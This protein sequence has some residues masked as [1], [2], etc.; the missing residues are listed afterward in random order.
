MLSFTKIQLRM[1][2]W[3]VQ[4]HNEVSLRDAD[5]KISKS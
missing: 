3:R 2:G 4:N 1:R 5:A